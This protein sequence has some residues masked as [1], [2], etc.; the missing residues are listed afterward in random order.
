[1]CNA[2]KRIQCVDDARPRVASEAVVDSFVARCAGDDR[3]YRKFGRTDL[4]ALK[5]KLAD[6]MYA[7]LTGAALL[8][9]VELQVV[10]GNSPLASGLALLPL[11]VIV[12]ALSVRSGRL[13]TRIGPRLQMS[14]AR[15]WSA[16]A[17]PCS[18]SAPTVQLGGLRTARGRSCTR[19]LGLAAGSV[20]CAIT[21][22]LAHF[23]PAGRPP[24]MD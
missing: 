13:A 1:M 14:A 6:Q 22:H 18:R 7:A 19:C 24:R 17:W 3:I 4:P 2:V 21:A 16:R 10:W 11:I 23:G 15:W 9:P 12:L 8:L 20:T 5:K